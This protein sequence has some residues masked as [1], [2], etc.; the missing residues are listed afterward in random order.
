M[1]PGLEKMIDLSRLTRLKVRRS[2]PEEVAA[3][4]DAFFAAKEKDLKAVVEDFQINHVHNS[5]MY[6]QESNR[7]DGTPWLPLPVLRRAM[8]C[9]V[10]TRKTVD[11]SHVQLAR[12]IHEEIEKRT[13]GKS[14]EEEPLIDLDFSTWI[15]LLSMSGQS[16]KARELLLSENPTQS[17]IQAACWLN[18]LEGL[19]AEGNGD[20]MSKSISLLRKLSVPFTRGMQQRMVE[21]FADK[22]DLEQAKY[23][24]MQPTYNGK[25][26][27]SPNSATNAAILRCCAA[28]QDIASGQEVIASILKVTPQKRDWDSIFV[29]SAAT[30]KGVDE[31]NRMMEV[32]VQRM[33][34]IGKS[35]RPDVNTINSLVEYAM[36]KN[37]P[38]SA[39]R[40]VNLGQKR[41]IQPNAQ[42]FILQMEYRLS[43]ND[44]EGARTAYFGLQGEDVPED[45]DVPIIN[46]LIQAMCTGTRK[47]DFD[48]IMGIVDDLGARK[49]R[50]ES[51][52]VS[53]LCLLHLKRG[54]LRDVVD[55]LQTHSYHYSSEQ[56]AAVRNVLVRFCL[57]RETSTASAWDA[58]QICRNVFDET[59]REIRTR[60]MNNFFTRGRSDMACHVFFHMR[61]HSNHLIRATADTYVDAFMGFA[62]AEDTESLE[63]IHNQMKLDM[64]IEPNTRMR[65]ALMFAYTMTENPVRAM[66]FWQEIFASNEGP[67]YSSI[68]LAFR[69]CETMPF[70]DQHAKPIWARLMRMDVEVDKEVFAAYVGALAGNSLHEEAQ[71]L[72]LKAEE[73][74]GFRP[75][76]LILGTMYNATLSFDKQDLLEEF[77]KQKF[78]DV[79]TE[80]EAIGSTSTMDGFGY[81]QFN[82]NRDVNP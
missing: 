31:I 38:Y 70:G 52:T 18:I 71:E 68:K 57:D 74:F 69:A 21:W 2:P 76:V 8:S 54:E 82:I 28:N 39:E 11:R 35:A 17:K 40:Y 10:K 78:P 19:Q 7:P 45:E 67:S 15:R 80:L 4:F 66:E 64:E 29:W 62:H 13:A 14:R 34:Q 30:G 50:L 53:A 3:A 46:K 61:H 44:I 51:D 47:Y 25:D 60:I 65:N 12:I 27:T 81:K 20:E 72:V 22:G 23:W 5:F 41:G 48:T 56:R 42:T 6:L 32:M 58:Y 49:A 73:E 77:I 36:S 33:E 55:L 1:T 75:D 9:L 16:L 43:V 59:P 63:L 26:H 37:D 24:Y 79:W